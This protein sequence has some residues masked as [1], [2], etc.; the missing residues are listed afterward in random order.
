MVYNRIPL[1]SETNHINTSEQH[2]Q[3]VMSIP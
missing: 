2:Y 3:Q 1:H